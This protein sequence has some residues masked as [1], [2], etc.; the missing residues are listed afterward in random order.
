MENKRLEFIDALKGFTIFLV[1]WGHTIMQLGGYPNF[2]YSIIYSF[3]MPLFFIISGFFFNSS[4]KLTLKDFLLKKSFQLLY[5]WFLWC[6][7][8]GI[9]Q[10]INHQLDNTNYL[11]KGILIFNRWFWFLRDLWLSY[12]TTYICYKIFKRGY[13][14][15]IF[16]F[17]FALLAPFFMI[18][19]FYL[20]LFLLGI[21]LKN[22]Y[23]YI[24]KHL[25]LFMY[26]S[27]FI[28]VFCL[29]FWN[30]QYL[31]SFPSFFSN[32]TYSYRFLSLY[33]S[34][35]RWLV[36]ISGSIF[37]ITFFHKTYRAN[38]FYSYF[39]RKSYYTLGIYILQV[40]IVENVLPLY[41]S[42]Q[43]IN[44]W[45]YALTIAPVISLIVLEVCVVIIG[46]V[47][48]NK[49]LVRLLFGNSY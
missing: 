19:S 45:T 20:P 37:F 12:V 14:V 7:I 48:K 25:N 38:I 13:L 16:G 6:I 5:P 8:L 4:L 31:S 36:A 39:N 41:I 3:H 27:F 46:W 2:T 42:F 11:Q 33:P 24:L 49:T 34:L 43:N 44:K 21:L 28:F 17:F 26:I 22:N 23:S 32:K 40:L 47:S 10:A 30:D 15:A 9:Y 18:Q 35:F 1:I 29:F